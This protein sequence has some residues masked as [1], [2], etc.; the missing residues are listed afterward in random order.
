MLTKRVQTDEYL[1]TIAWL[2]DVS[3]FSESLNGVSEREEN[4][5]GEIHVAHGR[6]FWCRSE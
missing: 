4:A 3:L 5:G 2:S 1:D 6:G